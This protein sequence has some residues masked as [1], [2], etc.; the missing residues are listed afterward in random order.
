M[1]VHC[2]TCSSVADPGFD[3][4]GSRKSGKVLKVEEKV[5]F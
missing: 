1:D 5:I 4:G 3:L 2:Y